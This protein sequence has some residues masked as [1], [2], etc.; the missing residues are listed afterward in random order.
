MLYTEFIT[1]VSFH[2]EFVLWDKKKY[3]IKYH[4]QRTR[5]KLGNLVI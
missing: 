1:V 2:A 3:M 5:I 4:M